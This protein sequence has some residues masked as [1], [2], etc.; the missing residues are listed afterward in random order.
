MTH[1]LHASAKEIKKISFGSTFSGTDASNTL[2]DPIGGVYYM[3]YRDTCSPGRSHAAPRRRRNRGRRRHG[4]LSVLWFAGLFSWSMIALFLLFWKAPASTGPELADAV[5]DVPLPV[6]PTPDT[7]ERNLSIPYTP[8]PGA[9]GP[10]M[11]CNTEYDFSLPVP[12]SD[13]VEDSYF[14]DAVFI[15]DSR[16]EGLILH[17]G[18]SNA[19]SYAY[20]GLMVDTV[21]SKPVIKKDGQKVSVMDA[22]SST[23]FSKVYIMLGINETGWV[24]GQVFQDK[25]GEIIDGIR[26]L[27]PDAAIYIQEIMPVSNEVS[28]THS[29]ITNDKIEEYN[30]LLRELA[31]EKQ[32]F[33]VD[34]GSAVA[35]ADGSLPEDGASDGIHLVK[36]Y[37]QKWLDYLK[38]HTAAG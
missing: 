10:D 36:E 11:D 32:V 26:E 13:P 3:E 6:L 5:A 14:D 25:Y 21:F 18:L 28:S 2:N 8:A 7:G 9:E 1:V 16:T 19:T 24:Y 31:E 23:S 34:T 30:G 27:N 17:T 38:T 12:A 15:G 4:V 20:K 33:Y 35:A 29:Y 22:L 37:C